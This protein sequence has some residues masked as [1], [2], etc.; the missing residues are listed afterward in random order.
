MIMEKK[1]SLSTS[2][3]SLL[4]TI[5]FHP[6]VVVMLLY[7][8]I[9][10][11]L[12]IIA[13]GPTDDLL[14]PFTAAPVCIVV[15]LLLD[16][17]PNKLRYCSWLILLPFAAS[18]FL[19]QAENWVDSIGYWIIT[20]VVAPLALLL[21]HRLS[22]DGEHLSRTLW[23]LWSVLLSVAIST[24]VVAIGYGISY[25]VDTLFEIDFS[26]DAM[27]VIMFFSYLLLAPMLFISIFEHE[28]YSSISKVVEFIT[29]WVITLALLI[30][31]AILYAYMLKILLTWTLP[32]G[33]VAV[34]CL[35]WGALSVFVTNMQTLLRQHPFAWFA[36]INA[37]LALPILLLL[38]VSVMRRVTDYGITSARYYLVLCSFIMTL[39]VIV[40]L[41]RIRDHSS[42]L[43]AL[44]ALL[45]LLSVMPGVGYVSVSVASQTR[46]A[47]I[48]AGRLGLLN[49][50][51]TINSS[52][53]DSLSDNEEQAKDY[54]KM[55][56]A[57]KIIRQLKPEA[58]DKL[59]QSK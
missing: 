39:F 56:D 54:D 49:P 7:C 15:C 4:G 25:C 51:G 16:H 21:Q 24:L 38:W 27:S 44:A 50:D 59:Y 42:R 23:F 52:G 12:E 19:P 46:Q 11:T 37:F 28:R 30:F 48:C 45:F 9:V 5:S 1:D 8:F 6:A 20:L 58:Y 26:S 32:C 17:L 2:L 35:A 47:S 34:M 40:N 18:C 10:S 36:K 41:L 31:T 13:D 57:L 43:T 29:N 55:Q 53:R 14:R 22:S 33:G 3:R